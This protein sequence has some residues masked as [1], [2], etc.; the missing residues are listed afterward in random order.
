M[1][2]RALVVA[3]LALVAARS[4][5]A[6]NVGEWIADLLRDSVAGRKSIRESDGKFHVLVLYRAEGGSLP[7]A[8][9]RHAEIITLQEKVND[10]AAADLYEQVEA[11]YGDKPFHC[12]VLADLLPQQVVAVE[13]FARD[14]GVVLVSLVTESPERG[15]VPFAFDPGKHVGFVR[16]DSLGTYGLSIQRPNPHPLASLASAP[17][18]DLDRC[19]PPDPRMKLERTENIC[20][21]SAYKRRDSESRGVWTNAIVDLD[22][23]M[24]Y[25]FDEQLDHRKYT[26]AWGRE[27]YHPHIG[28]AEYLSRFG[29][30]G[31]VAR[32]LLRAHFADDRTT[33]EERQK[34]TERLRKQCTSVSPHVAG[35]GIPTEARFP[36]VIARAPSY[37][38]P[39]LLPPL[40]PSF[41]WG[42]G[43]G[44]R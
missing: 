15:R 2:R 7:Y 13:Q 1:I 39:E 42:G 24:L 33:G 10:A 9:L 28:L 4:V 8:D 17:F 20:S 19:A 16:I 27:G 40:Q 5:A 21:S 38:D 37:A 35:G 32:E 22:V 26:R 30:C 6:K 12:I 36:I 43:L 44:L 29:D 14:Y 18:E 25:A 41:V 3:L 34:E 11:L 31:G 23:A